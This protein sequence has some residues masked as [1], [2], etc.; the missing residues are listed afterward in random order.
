MLGARPGTPGTGPTRAKKPAMPPTRGAARP[1]CDYPFY[2]AHRL[3]LADWHDWVGGAGE[4]DRVLAETSGLPRPGRAR[5]L[6]RGIG[7]GLIAA[8]RRVQGRPVAT[9]VAD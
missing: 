9:G 8:G 3:A 5:A 4:A 7:A 1:T 6:R 2:A